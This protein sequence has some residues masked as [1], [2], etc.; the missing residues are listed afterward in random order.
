MFVMYMYLLCV[1]I[2][3]FLDPPEFLPF[4]PHTPPL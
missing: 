1:L 2:K 3:F 4:G